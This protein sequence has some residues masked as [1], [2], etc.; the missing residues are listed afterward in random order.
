[1]DTKRIRFGFLLRDKKG[2]F[3][4]DTLPSLRIRTI[5][6]AL[7]ADGRQFVVLTVENPIKASDVL[8]AVEMFNTSIPNKSAEEVVVVTEEEEEKSAL[9]IEKFMECDIIVTF[10]KGQRFLQH[11]FYAVINEAKTCLIPSVILLNEGEVSPS[12][13]YWEWSFDGAPVSHRYKR[14]SGELASA[15]VEDAIS[16]SSAKRVKGNITTSNYTK[17]STTTTTGA[18]DDDETENH[19]DN[20]DDTDTTTTATTNNNNGDDNINDNNDNV[21]TVRYL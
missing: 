8:K 15:F 11:P 5:E 10:E 3:A 14:M 13:A 12:K 7:S 16:P 6:C 20:N 18:T 19:A 1:M 21:A 2:F 4:A 17:K 9:K